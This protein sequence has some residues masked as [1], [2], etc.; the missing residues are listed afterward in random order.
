MPCPLR[1]TT[2]L[3]FPALNAALRSC[4]SRTS[5]R[6]YAY[7]QPHRLPRIMAPATSHAFSTFENLEQILLHYAVFEDE[8]TTTTG[9]LHA[10]HR[11]E[12]KWRHLGRGITR[13][14]VS[15]CRV[16][17]YRHE[18]ITKSLSLQQIMF[19]K[20]KSVPAGLLLNPLIGRIAQTVTSVQEDDT[21]SP[22][23]HKMLA[24]QTSESQVVL[25]GKHFSSG[26]YYSTIDVSF[27][28]DVRIRVLA[29]WIASP[30]FSVSCQR[31]EGQIAPVMALESDNCM[32]RV[33]HKSTHGV[34]GR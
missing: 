7:T 33:C 25:Q 31:V 6:A 24:V 15:A 28:S 20:Q 18:T 30:R 32:K 13:L 8:Q 4:A 26:G 17:W 12:T 29:T 27:A 22:T 34:G 10:K 1:T 2:I 14:L 5:A 21:L 3:R 23:W 16:N 9:F 11:P 19:F